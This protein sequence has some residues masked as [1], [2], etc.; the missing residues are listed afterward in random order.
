M[1]RQVQRI[2]SAQLVRPK[3]ASRT[4][5]PKEVPKEFSCDYNESCMVFADSPKASAALSRRCLQ[6]ILREKAGV[7][8]DDLANEIQQVIDSRQ[9]PSHLADSLDAVRNIGAF[10]AHPI[11]S[12][13]TGE[14]VEVEPG[15][16]E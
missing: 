2:N 14:I 1:S 12:K 6:H 10:A 3:V 7:K 9:L 15:E 5:V 11:K 8:K 16:A 13:T 4:P